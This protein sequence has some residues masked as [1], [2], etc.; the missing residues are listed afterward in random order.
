[1]GR[2]F[3]GE[4]LVAGSALSGQGVERRAH[5]AACDRNIS[6]LGAEF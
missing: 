4:Q 1:M 5:C 3:P 2:V 6:Q